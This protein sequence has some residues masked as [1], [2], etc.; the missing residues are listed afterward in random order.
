MLRRDVG[1]QAEETA[2][3]VYIEPDDELLSISRKIRDTIQKNEQP[4]SRN[5]MDDFIDRVMAVPLIPGFL[6]G[7]VK[8]ADRRGILPKRIIALSPFHTSMFISNLASIQ[9]NYVYHHLYEFGTTSL[10]ITLGMPRRVL[11]PSGEIKR[12]MT[13]GISLDER[14][15]KGATWA[16]ALFE[17]QRSLQTPERL[18][19]ERAEPAQQEK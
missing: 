10:F 6:I 1:G 15:C 4:Q 2:V 12:M 8:W 13:L 5:S 16:K 3:K 19:G 9:M 11:G 14:I 7:L 18:L 17:F